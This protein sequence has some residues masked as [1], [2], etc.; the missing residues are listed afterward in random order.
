MQVFNF[1][2]AF[3]LLKQGYKVRVTTYPTGL[4]YDKKVGNQFRKFDKNGDSIDNTHF[5]RNGS[6]NGSGQMFTLNEN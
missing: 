3:Y 6:E 2:T 1:E 5:W 4:E